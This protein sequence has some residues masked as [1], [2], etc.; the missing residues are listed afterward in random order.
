MSY[1]PGSIWINN[2]E[3]KISEILSEKFTAASEFE[4]ATFSFIRN[5]LEGTE[6]FNLQTSGS[7]G[8]PKEITLSRNQFKQ[9]ANRTLTALYLNQNDTAF[10]C[11]DTKYIAGKMMLVRALE[12]DLK[13]LAVEPT[14]NP[15]QNLSSDISTGFAAFVPMQF[16]EILKH[17][18]SAKKLN[19]LKAI[20]IGGGAVSAKLH[21]A[22]QK[23]SCP[24]FATYGMTETVSHIA[25]QRLNGDDTSDYF[26]VLSGINIEIDQRGCLVIQIP[27]FAEKIV[28]NDLVELIGSDQF[29]WL[30]RYDNVIN[31]GGFKISPEKIEKSLESILPDRAFFVTHFLDERLGEKLVVVMEGNRINIDF[32]KLHLHPY[33]IPKEVIYLPE[34][35]RTE[36]GK[37]NRIKTMRLLGIG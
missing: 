27:E 5:W 1:S 17:S 23:I 6:K 22:I 29:R 14:A 31:S 37:I 12:G 9:S 15:L 13:I 11:L 3:I 35:I 16:Q 7:T 10:V 34:F 19:Q 25:L 20:I 26:K 8:T 21:Q 24:V 2:R 36:T 28:T 33:E 4:S 18:D 30:G 32:S